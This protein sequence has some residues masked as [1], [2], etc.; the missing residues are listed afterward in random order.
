MNCSVYPSSFHPYRNASSNQTSSFRIDDILK[1]STAFATTP[2]VDPTSLWSSFA[3]QLLSY[4]PEILTLAS[5]H[6]NNTHNHMSLPNIPVVN[7]ATTLNHVSP[8]IPNLVSPAKPNR[9]HS[10]PYLSTSRHSPTGKLQHD[11]TSMLTISTN[12]N[13]YQ[14]ALSPLSIKEKLHQPIDRKG[15]FK[16]R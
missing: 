3:A 6:N 13:N 12:K 11:S 4:S 9:L 5:T 8:P 7:A 14:H 2:T 15:M 10:H 16:H 1:P